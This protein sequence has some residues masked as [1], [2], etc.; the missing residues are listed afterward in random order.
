MSE[1]P[2]PS[3]YP[4]QPLTTAQLL[5]NASDDVD[6]NRAFFTSTPTVEEKQEFTSLVHYVVKVAKARKEHHPPVSELPMWDHKDD[7][8]REMLHAMQTVN[9][10]L[11]DFCIA[12]ETKL[13]NSLEYTNMLA[14][15]VGKLILPM[16]LL[17]SIDTNSYHLYPQ[18]IKSRKM[19]VEHAISK[20]TLLQWKQ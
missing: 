5:E 18:H 10:W 19:E 3:R 1:Q 16:L 17:H 2:K 9:I 6:D 8:A 11:I 14:V 4:D 20:T 15:Y 13:G 7:N 12:T